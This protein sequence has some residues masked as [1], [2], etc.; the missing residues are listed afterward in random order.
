MSSS[1]TEGV[2]VGAMVGDQGGGRSSQ[3]LPQ[4]PAPPAISPLTEPTDPGNREPSVNVTLDAD[5]EQEGDQNH[6]PITST[7]ASFPSGTAP[8]YVDNYSH[9]KTE[10]EELD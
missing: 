5:P 1:V 2:G 9:L 6:V 3:S 10:P 8:F 7:G 4:S